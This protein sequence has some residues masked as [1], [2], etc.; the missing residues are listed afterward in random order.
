MSSRDSKRGELN[1]PIQS[2]GEKLL[3]K[4]EFQRLSEVPPE[5]EWFAKLHVSMK[6]A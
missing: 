4:I 5:A 6:I 2:E 3:S 1:P